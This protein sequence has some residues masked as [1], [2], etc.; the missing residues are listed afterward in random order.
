M[1]IKGPTT[2]QYDACGQAKI[3]RQIRRASRFLNKDPPAPR[4]RIAIDFHD[5][6]PDDEGY[7][8]LMLVSDREAGFCWDYY[9]KDESG[10]TI[11]SA[12]DHLL[13]LFKY[14]YRF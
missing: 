13:G 14:E 8:R 2:V 5:F 1:R 4:E 10:E 6:I 11:I 7:R 3:R 9:M 12:L